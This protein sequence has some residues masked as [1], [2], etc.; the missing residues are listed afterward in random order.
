MRISLYFLLAILAIA[1]HR[2]SVPQQ[3]S[4]AVPATP[5]QEIP[6][7]PAPLPIMAGYS[8]NA[9]VPLDPTIRI[10]K[11]ENGM[12]YYI[13][14]NNKPENRAELRMAL[15]AGS[16]QEDEDQLGL[17][18]FIEHMAFNGSEN[19]SKNELVNYLEKA[20]SQF[21]PDL[22]AYT[23]FDE[24]VYMLQVRTDA[25]GQLDSGMLI[26]KDWASGVSFDPEEIEKERGVVI[27]EW[28][29][30]L[31]AGQRMMN[32]YLPFMYYQ[33]RYADR[34][35]IG[36]PQI[37]QTAKPDVI[38][39]FYND[40]YRPELMA[41]M[42]VGNVDPDA[43]E[44]KIKSDFGSIKPKAPART[45]P[46]ET[47]AI[48]PN[49][50]VQVLTDPEATNTSINIDFKHKHIPVSDIAGYRRQLTY[51]IYS[52]MISR[53]LQERSKTADAPFV[54]ASSYYYP[55]VADLA[56][57]SLYATAPAAGIRQA[58]KAILEENRRVQQ[59]GFTQSELDRQKET[60]LQQAE[61]SMKESN[62]MESSRTVRR[63]INHY[64]DNTPLPNEEQHY[65][66]Y[67]EMIPTIS[68]NEINSLSNKWLTK[69]NRVVLLTAPEKEKA[70]LPDSTELITILNESENWKLSPY[71]DVDL[72]API[73]SQ[74]LPDEEARNVTYDP[75]TNVSTW[76]FLN[77][78]TVKVK[79][80]E[81]KNDEVLMNAYS[82]GGTSLYEDDIYHTASL[83]AN[84]IYGGGVGPYKATSLDKKLAGKRVSVRP[85]LS[86]RFEGFYGNSNVK[87]LETMLQ[88]VYGY[89]TLYRKDN[90]ALQSSIK[91]QQNIFANLDANPDAWFS[92]KMTR[93]QTQNHKRRVFPK[94]SDFENI[95]LDDVGK[96]YADRFSDFSDM[97]FFFVGN[98]NIE[99]L[100]VLTGKYLGSL[101]GKGRKESYKDVGV[102]YPAGVLDSV[103]SKGEAPKSL[104]QLVFHGNTTY[105]PDSNYL[106]NTLV[107]V[108]RIKLREALREDEGGVYG[109]SV[110]G[111]ST[112][113]PREEYSLTVSFNADP[114]RAD[115]LTKVALRVIH[116]LQMEIDQDVILKAVETQKQQRI[117]D[118]EQNNFWMNAMISEYMYKIP[119]RDYTDLAILE[120]RI[121]KVTPQRL[122]AAARKYFNEKEL[123]K[124]TMHPATTKS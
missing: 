17:A 86:E 116:N 93:L 49:T 90:D 20:G 2:K 124:G 45:K 12:T 97:T 8:D 87:D 122:Q 115:S 37:I 98:V 68:L 120:N 9:P 23:S 27:S 1:C 52:Q 10:G 16:M 101:P 6:E 67:K 22:N 60:I 11:L 31:S 63:M 80:T 26:L 59:H 33:S 64:L 108:A 61:Q 91:Q 36:D 55:D 69:D 84:V 106:F 119:L 89:G 42:V 5:S 4:S 99:T 103:F 96:I 56:M 79:P 47:M 54:S 118:L 46:V 76:Q 65:L 19:F 121:S 75:V 18:H 25:E 102:K 41:I 13:K 109:V 77:G 111:S 34:L 105:H 29:S 73:I 81:F 110:N 123:I 85:T 39:R 71:E 51:S 21:G 53:R 117:K 88:L 94:A 74:T 104:V 38:R 28:R 35:P 40:W 113:F 82:P 7:V 95:K 100:K 44:A 3:T 83:T 58:Y 78:V 112:N 30:R 62:K 24:T 14:V 50:F 15:K 107:S 43:M 114:G 92:D 72:S 70:L 48:T 57:Y 32:K 66:L